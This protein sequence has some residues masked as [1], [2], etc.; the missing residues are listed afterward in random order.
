M[1]ITGILMTGPLLFS[2]VLPCTRALPVKEARKV[3]EPSVV[4]DVNQAS[5][6]DFEKLP[7]IGPE[8]ARRIVE[9]RQKHG[10]F[11]RVEDLLAVRGI[12]SKKWRALRPHLRVGKSG[13]A[14]SG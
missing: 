1:R 5:A 4:I 10:P 3:L 14:G 13:G 12:G 6:T 9:F 2:S 7:G 8:L 11:R